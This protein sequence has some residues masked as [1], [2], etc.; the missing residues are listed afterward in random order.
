MQCTLCLKLV[1][2]LSLLHL[3]LSPSPVGHAFLSLFN[4][5]LSTGPLE[6]TSLFNIQLFV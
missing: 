4:L 1:K 2:H 3:I 6:H 5:I